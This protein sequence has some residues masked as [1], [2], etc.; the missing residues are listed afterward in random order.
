MKKI[1][2]AIAAILIYSNLFAE[3]FVGNYNNMK[4]QC[5]HWDAPSNGEMYSI[6][7]RMTKRYNSAPPD[8]SQIECYSPF[9]GGEEL[10]TYST[11]SWSAPYESYDYTL[12]DGHYFIHYTANCAE[13][14]WNSTPVSQA[15]YVIFTYKE[16]NPA[17]GGVGPLKTQQGWFYVPR[18]STAEY[19]FPQTQFKFGQLTVQWTHS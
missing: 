4:Y 7:K 19:T 5:Q 6:S 13:L 9:W 2:A 12:W 3:D 17:T 1:L 14:F 10:C 15:A 18:F 16:V 8:F 11:N